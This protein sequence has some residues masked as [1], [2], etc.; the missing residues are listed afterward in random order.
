MMPLDRFLI[1]SLVT[2]LQLTGVIVIVGF[3]LGYAGILLDRAW[4]R[5]RWA[6]L[7]GMVLGAAMV[8][9]AFPAGAA[10]ERWL[11]SR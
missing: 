8:I 4:M 1:G 7:T 11:A 2:A 10:A 9:G 3:G 6:R 5:R